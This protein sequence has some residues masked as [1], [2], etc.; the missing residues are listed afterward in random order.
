MLYQRS[1]RG[2][3]VT[4]LTRHHLVTSTS[5]SSFYSSSSAVSS[6]SHHH[7]SSIIINS[8][9]SSSFS[10]SPLSSHLLRHY[11]R[12]KGKVNRLIRSALYKDNMML[13]RVKPKLKDSYMYVCTSNGVMTR[14]CWEESRITIVRYMRSV[15]NTKYNIKFYGTFKRPITK[16]PTGSRMGKGKAG[17]DHY[18]HYFPH[19]SRVLEI[20]NIGQDEAEKIFRMMQN[21]MPFN[22][23]MIREY[24]PGPDILN[25]V[26]EQMEN[27]QFDP[28]NP[29]QQY[30]QPQNVETEVKQSM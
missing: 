11:A 20:T 26:R 22:L 6:P 9:S 25:K 17:V 19:N 24:E 27:D 15:K 7:P 2:K 29:S 23:K 14:P 18:V 3:S 16:K 1:L 12:S 5:A 13:R 30:Q 10:V 8:T 4:S 21:V 28:V